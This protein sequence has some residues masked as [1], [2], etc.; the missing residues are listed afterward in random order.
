MSKFDLQQAVEKIRSTPNGKEAAMYGPLRDIFVNVFEYPSFDVDIDTAGDEGRP[1]VTVRAPTG[2]HDKDGKA[3][4]TAWIV[5]EAKDEHDAFSSLDSRE[6]IFAK[7]AKYIGSNTAWFVMA[8]P[9]VLVARPVGGTGTYQDI[10]IRWNEVSDCQLLLGKLPRLVAGV[11]GV[12]VFLERFRAGEEDMIATERLAR[13]DAAHATKR[14]MSRYRVTRKRFFINLREATQHLQDACRNALR[15]V[16]GQVEECRRLRD[17]FAV[18]YGT[19]GAGEPG[20]NVKFDSST[21]LLTGKPVGP[22]ASR[23]HDAESRAIRRKFSKMPHMARLALDYLPTFQSRTGADEDKIEDLFAIETANLILARILLVRF[24][25]DHQFF[26]PR[27]YICNGGVK[28]FQEMRKYF[29]ESYTHLLGA[30][31]QRAGR[32]YAAA[33]DETELDWVFGCEDQGL[34]NAIEWALF[35]FSRYD[36]TTIRGDILTG[37]YDRFMDR[38][39]RKE[40]GEFFTPPSI[41]RYIIRRMNLQSGDKI[42]DP[43][44]GSGTFLIE[45]FRELVGDDV[46]RG[47]VEYE[48]VLN[49]LSRL[50]GNDLNTFS[51]VLAQ[52]QILW[53]ILPFKEGIEAFG[54]P[55]LNITGKANSLVIPDH[56]GALERF[57]E[58][59]VPE[60]A[61]VVGNPPYVRRERSAQ[62]LDA[63]S[64]NE[65]QHGR[66]GFPGVSGK[67][68]SYALFVYRALDSWCRPYIEG[69]QKAGKLGFIIQVSLFDSNETADLR[70]LFRIGE[71]WTIR[72][73]IDLEIIYRSVFDADVLPAIIICE[74]RPATA[75]DLVSIRIA[76][77]QCVTEGEDGGLPTFDLDALPESKIPYGNLFTPDGRIMTRLNDMR[78]RIIR[79]LWENPLLETAIRPFWVRTEKNKI[80]EWTDQAPT[81]HGK[82]EQ[83]RLLARGVVFRQMRGTKPN[84]HLIYKGENIIAGEL[85]GDPSDRDID[86][87]KLS[88]DALWRYEEILPNT[89]YAVAQV[90]HCTNAV[91][92]NPHAMA[93]T[94]TATIFVPRMDAEDVPFDLVFMSHVYVYFYALAA[95]MGVLRTCRS[96]IYPTNLAL[97]PWNDRLIGVALDIEALRGDLVSACTNEAQGMAALLDALY[98]LKFASLKDRI[99]ADKSLRIAFGENFD[100]K[101]YEAEISMPNEKRVDAD[102]WRVSLSDDILDWVEVNSQPLAE[103][104]RKAAITREGGKLSKSGILGLSVPLTLEENQN[105]DNTVSRFDPNVLQAARAAVLRNLDLIVGK[106]LGLTET[107]IT[108][109]ESDCASDPFL[110]RIRPR[111]PGTVTRKQG[112]R[113][114]LDSAA[115]W[116]T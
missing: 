61:A 110:K 112:F 25:E 51:S 46:D 114:G 62:A 115:R 107:D 9:N 31:Y 104:I 116:H 78:L 86:L 91:R 6:D 19:S 23:A 47:A 70:N 101:G 29:A 24:F 76:D 82:W 72:E 113:T 37:I 33:F 88:D 59:D 106:A 97:L 44:C 42:F 71:R 95:R 32:L 73:I 22:V 58:I 27:R 28:A 4:K 41:A 55:D 103:G 100:A 60:Y 11:A 67:L 18:A 63:R 13:P 10:V 38:G 14:E 16:M 2:L 108:A 7:K 52:I 102:V 49:A 17:D 26:G 84:G 35:Q 57:G 90:A 69:A 5:I 12:S 65:F 99:K 20:K 109:I 40:M 66:H 15:G 53:Q 3:I 30:A 45:A 93:F 111:Y 92:F 83:K 89:A 85:Q 74:N 34:S 105:W 68:N 77:K 81:Q 96:H 64:V 21:L 48:D 94:D 75:E 98:A 36:F 8:D 1:D 79:E 43:A 87:S 56:F 39:K 50:F 80:V 54:L